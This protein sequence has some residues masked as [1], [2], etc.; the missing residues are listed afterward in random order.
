MVTCQLMRQTKLTDYTRKVIKL[1]KQNMFA[2]MSNTDLLG[3]Y[4][5]YGAKR[6]CGFYNNRRVRNAAREEILAR[7]LEVPQQ[8]EWYALL[9]K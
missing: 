9:R 8:V 1:T 6:Q 4:I 2:E 7:G 3:W 5:Q